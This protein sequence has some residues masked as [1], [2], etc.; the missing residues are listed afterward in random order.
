M[1]EKA[2]MAKNLATVGSWIGFAVVWG[3]PGTF[4]A[5]ITHP[6]EKSI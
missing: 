3:N 4:G 6:L 2:A 5:Q 1:L